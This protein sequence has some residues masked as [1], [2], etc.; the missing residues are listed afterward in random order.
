M[1]EK[2]TIRRLGAPTMQ[3]EQKVSRRARVT[4]H[5]RSTGKE[6]TKKNKQARGAR[7]EFST[8]STR[9]IQKHPESP[10]A[11][12]GGEIAAKWVSPVG[13]FVALLLFLFFFL[14]RRLDRSSSGLS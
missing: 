13:D 8:Y 1:V 14:I 7:E 12:H 11:N 9:W 10:E 3:D 2:M 5:R 4:D 6:E